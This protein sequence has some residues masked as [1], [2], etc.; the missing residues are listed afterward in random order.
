MKKVFVGYDPTQAV[1][2][3]VC[4]D[5]L[6]RHSSEPIEIIP[7]YLPQLSTYKELHGDG[8]N[9]FIYSRFLVPHLCHFQGLALFIDGDMVVNGDVC[10]LFA[11]AENGFSR[12]VWVCKHDYKT[13]QQVK[14]RGNRNEDYPRKNWS[15]VIMWN[16]ASFPNRRLSP[17]YVQRAGGAELHRFGWIPD[18]RIGEIPPEWNWLVGEYEH[19]D[20]AKLYHYTLGIPE[21]D[22]CAE[23]DHSDA[24]SCAKAKMMQCD[25]ERE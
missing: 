9:Q 13:K 20:N 18:D 21:F 7:L 25:K 16:C 10:D 19:N 8:S 12:S 6:I 11:M 4:V 15:S 17:E 5:S 1:A 14:Y 2:F 3:H 22:E 23:S 24:W